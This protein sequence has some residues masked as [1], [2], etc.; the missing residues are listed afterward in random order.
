[1]AVILQYGL[2][3]KGKIIEKAEKNF[4]DEDRKNIE[5]AIENLIVKYI[6]ELLD[7][8]NLDIEEIESI[9]IACPRT[10]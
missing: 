7:I 10:Y 1:M 3:D 5:K 6:N 8:S 2:V 9:G 4:I